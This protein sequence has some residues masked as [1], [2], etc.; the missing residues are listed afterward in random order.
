MGT[1]KREGSYGKLQQAVGEVSPLR[2][3][4]KKSMQPLPR[5]SGTQPAAQFAIQSHPIAQ[6][7]RAESWI[8][9]PCFPPAPLSL[10]MCT[11]WHSCRGEPVCGAVPGA[12]GQHESHRRG[13]GVQSEELFVTTAARSRQGKDTRRTEK[14]RA[15]TPV[16]GMPSAEVKGTGAKCGAGRA[17]SSLS[18]GM[19]LFIPRDGTSSSCPPDPV[20]QDLMEALSLQHTVLEMPQPWEGAQKH[21]VMGHSLPW[22]I[23]GTQPWS[24]FPHSIHPQSHPWSTEPILTPT[25]L[26]P[27][28]PSLPHGVCPQPHSAYP[29]S[30]RPIPAPQNLSP[31]PPFTQKLVWEHPPLQGSFGHSLPG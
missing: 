5:R 23:G 18:L 21:P 22:P 29:Q 11:K 24:L 12:L 2:L 19:P 13:W 7:L 30:Q 3:F 26:N 9:G 1:P 31:A 20:V 4:L 6:T 14:V 25:V 10:W 27:R 17:A 28:D 8:L 15:A 16:A